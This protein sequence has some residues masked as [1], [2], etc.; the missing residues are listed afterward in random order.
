M[1][2]CMKR[3]WLP[4]LLSVPGFSLPEGPLFIQGEGLTESTAPRTLEVRAS[5]RSIL[6]WDAFSV[7]SDETVVFD[8]PNIQSAILNRIVGPAPS[9]IFGRISSNGQVVFINPNGV[10]V[11]R[12]AVIDTARWIASTLDLQDRD[13]L[14]SQDWSFAG[15]S[16]APIEIYGQIRGGQTAVLARDILCAGKLD[17]ARI[18]LAAAMAARVTGSGIEIHQP[19]SGTL[20]FSG[21][22]SAPTISL[23]GTFLSLS[24]ELNGSSILVGGKEYTSALAVL[25]SARITTPPKGE[26]LLLAAGS[27]SFQGEVYSPG[28]F[29][30]VSGVRHL[31]FRGKVDTEKTGVLLLDPNDITITSLGVTN[32]SPLTPN[33]DGSPVV[34]ST[35]LNTDLTA[36]L[37]TN[38]VTIQTSSSVA[39]GNGDI[40]VEFGAPV[41]WMSGT[42]LTLHAANSIFIND[43]IQANTSPSVVTLVADQ[44]DIVIVST[45]FALTAAGVEINGSYPGAGSNAVIVSAPN[46]ALSLISAVDSPAYIQTTDS[47]QAGDIRI[48]ANSIDLTSATPFANRSDAGIFGARSDIYVT[49]TGAMTFVTADGTTATAH[50]EIVTGNSPLNLIVGGNLYFSAGSLD[51]DNSA[52][53][54]GVFGATAL[55]AY[56]VDGSTGLVSGAVAGDVVFRAGSGIGCGSGI[57]SI[58][59]GEIDVA[60]GGNATFISSPGPTANFCNAG[61]ASVLTGGMG[62]TRNVQASIGGN[63]LAIC[64]GGTGSG[65][66][67]F[68]EGSLT[69]AIAGNADFQTSNGIG[70]TAGDALIAT[71]SIDAA[72]EGNLSFIG[73]PAT[74]L[75]SR[76]SAGQNV[77]IAAKGTL[78]FDFAN[79]TAGLGEISLASENQ[80][81]LIT[82]GTTLQSDGELLA[83][84][85]RN[86]EMRSSAAASTSGRIVFIVDNLYPIR[87]LIGTGALI[88]NPS[89]LTA[90]LGIS[91]YTA[92]QELNSITDTTFNGASFAPGALFV[93][94]S[95]EV[96][97]SYYPEGTTTSPFTIF[98]KDCVQ[99]LTYDGSLVT[100]EF[101]RDPHP[102]DEPWGW[103]QTFSIQA[104]WATERYF[105]R[106][107]QLMFNNPKS[108]TA[109]LN[110]L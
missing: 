61:I 6:H 9:E 43:L 31:D 39:G 25:P 46:G 103:H 109:I 79:V 74:P 21:T 36:L 53:M 27:A 96:W 72:V 85:G 59:E 42:N 75:P 8:L 37:A 80:S 106:R 81:I 24:G 26:T 54:S 3:K 23:Q 50:A 92:R 89:S 68:S 69:V 83:E 65:A 98:Y 94:T 11:G 91:L 76:I 12:E 34:A 58:S 55:S 15:E 16:S 110:G 28:G 49:A 105:L 2:G 41:S 95:N 40:T 101:L 33:Y 18:D 78:S 93:N 13:F 100:S 19:S 30:E 97:C 35:I 67:F 4:L 87:P 63:V 48:A 62:S 14:A 22:A 73:T 32:P 1:L 17:G 84:A 57:S 56:G 88:T 47:I 82:N 104:E 107:R 51:F 86:I 90:A 20:S 71:G 70:L 29:V 5:D 66:G 52:V 77:F 60:I 102:Y 44:G 38:S 45:D 64:G 108:W 7:A 99:I 10:L